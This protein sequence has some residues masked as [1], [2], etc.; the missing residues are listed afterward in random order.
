M[1]TP[2]NV[3]KNIYI[4]IEFLSR[5][6]A[7]HILT[8]IFLTKKNFRVYLGDGYSLKKLLV[9]KNSKGGIFIT[10]GNLNKKISSLVKKKCEKIIS[11]DQE[12]TPGF[13][14][15]FYKDF[16]KTRYSKNIK[17][18]DLFLC[19]NSQIKRNLI[20]V[21]KINKNKV[22]ETGWPR[23]D[24][25]RKEFRDLYKNQIKKL[26]KKYRKFYLFNSDFGILTDEEF[27]DKK[28]FLENEINKGILKKYPNIINIVLPFYN[29]KDFQNFRNF[30]KKIES[31]K[32]PKIIFRPHPAES[33]DEW[34]KIKKLSPKFIIDK[35]INDVTPII[36]A[37][38]GL[39]HRGCTTAFQSLIFNKKTAYL[40]LSNGVKKT[41]EFR[42]VLYDNS[43][44]INSIQDLNNWFKKKNK[45]TNLKKI[46]K[47]LN[48]KKKYSSEIIAE[49]LDNLNITKEKKHNQFQ[50]YSE[51][52]IRILS[53]KN[54]VYD[55][56]SFLSLV[57]QRNYFKKGI[58]TKIGKNFNIYTISGYINFFKKK[59]KYKKKIKVRKI[60]ENLFE[61]D[62]N[63]EII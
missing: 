54:L 10:K 11:L 25:Y 48:M 24:L 58:Q 45:I 59:L 14:D 16:I 28:K 55:F 27:K 63:S 46:L 60:T 4:H 32:I 20:K 34:E 5:E 31:K 50:L 26:I 61:L 35:P 56:F 38:N 52:E 51:T 49:H 18:I 6:L 44:I 36:L 41:N 57:K 21:L 47:K 1:K 43:H 8:S 39:L 42:S 3:K 7:S 9:L 29:V 2:S 62:S 33:L 13:R 53:Y 17:N 30:L 37:S 40:N 23:F 15:E 12:I 22:I 19:N